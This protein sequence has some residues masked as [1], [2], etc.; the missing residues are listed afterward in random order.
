MGGIDGNG[1]PS[2]MHHAV[3]Y[4]D[5]T[6]FNDIWN[7]DDGVTWTLVATSSAWTPRRSMSVVEFNGFLWMFGG[8]SP[9]IGYQSDVWQSADGIVWTRA[10]EHAAFVPREGQWAEVWN[11]RIW[12][13]G[14]V[15]YEQRTTFN[16]VWY[17]DNGVDWYKAPEAPWPPRWDHATAIFNGRMWLTGGMDLGVH[18]DRAFDDEWVTDDGL[19][20]T[21]V[22]AHAP[23]PGR[24]GHALVPYQGYLW[25]VGRLN[26]DIDGGT[27][28]VWYSP[29]G[30]T[31]MEA[32]R[33]DWAGREDHWVIPFRDR[34]WV[35][36]GMDNLW[37]WT[38]DVW[39][40]TELASTSTPPLMKKNQKPLVL[41]ARAYYSVYVDT[42]GAMYPLVSQHALD[43]F[44]LASVSKLMTGLVAAE[45]YGLGARM[46][47][48]RKLLILSDNVTAD[49]LSNA[50]FVTRMNE[51][52]TELGLSSMHFVNPSG[53]DGATMNVGSAADVA[54]LITYLK[55]DR[56][57]LFE[58]LGERS[59]G[60]ATST[61]NLLFEPDLG[62]I[63]GKT[64]E[65]PHARQNLVIVSKAPRQGY[66]VSVVLGSD[67]RFQDMRTLLG[68]V[69]SS[70][71][72]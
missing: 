46:D 32:P 3:E 67:D 36:S 72:W 9:K 66:L 10:V 16:D 64:G 24:Q 14:G 43:P 1:T 27:N 71:D 57:A 56:Q 50:N 8:W 52:A 47:Q 33:P 5:A 13:T 63:A 58:I 20:W 21:Q 40:S 7:S 34:L 11:G 25:L 61:N 42:D 45:T 18:K 4:G 19:T 30:T 60:D 70:F 55:T 2:G 53:L 23:W 26:D 69:T 35:F 54:A 31:W 48:I 65:T 51:R 59:F 41:S 12:M 6:Y 17:T 49:A 39:V 37:H 22:Y 62:V 28:S 38:N 15:N 29:D 68:Y 44:P